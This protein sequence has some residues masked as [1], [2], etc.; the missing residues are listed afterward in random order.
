M[1]AER[2]GA[3]LYERIEYS[4]WVGQTTFRAIFR[5]ANVRNFP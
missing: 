3:T 4:E 5:V 2:F 1:T